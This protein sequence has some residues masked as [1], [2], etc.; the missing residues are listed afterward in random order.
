MTSS[1]VEVTTLRQPVC[2][3]CG[4]LGE[5]KEQSDADATGIAVYHD[6]IWHSDPQPEGY[7][8]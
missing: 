7:D 6:S 5:L 4:P 3:E 8:A 1:T 2:P